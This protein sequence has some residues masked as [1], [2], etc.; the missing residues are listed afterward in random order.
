[1]VKAPQVVIESSN[2]MQQMLVNGNNALDAAN[3]HDL[4]TKASMLNVQV[5]VAKQYERSIPK[6]RAQVVELCQIPQ[7]AEKA[8]YAYPRG[9]QVVIGPSIRLIEE[10]ACCM[11]NIEYG[12]IELQQTE[13]EILLEAFA[14][15][16][17][18][19][20]RRSMRWTVPMERSTKKG[21]YALTDQRDRYEMMA[22]MGMRR[23]RACLMAV[24]PASVQEI[25]IETVQTTLANHSRLIS[26]EKQGRMLE[27]FASFSVERRHIE[28][29]LTHKLDKLSVQ[30]AMNLKSI[31]ESLEAGMSKPSDFFSGVVDKSGDKEQ[32]SQSTNESVNRIN[33]KLNKQKQPAKSKESGNAAK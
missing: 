32:S 18:K 2:P 14:W 26:P 24:I 8:M 11:G 33:E 12:I 7:L 23:V 15:D 29:Y 30:E 16:I 9:G 13:K 3:Q 22:N 6:V 17:E 20:V 27:V 1:M 28:H 4:L 10:L 5:Q 25:A 31:C 21:S 19:N